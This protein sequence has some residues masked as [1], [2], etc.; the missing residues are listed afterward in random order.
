[1]PE[2]FGQGGTMGA[3]QSIRD[4]G[5]LLEMLSGIARMAGQGSD[6]QTALAIGRIPFGGSLSIFRRSADPTGL[7]SYALTKAMAMNPNIF[8][9]TIPIGG[10]SYD[11]YGDKGNLRF[12]RFLTS[13]LQRGGR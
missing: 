9:K 10:F 5:K 11:I 7:A 4:G 3:S 6:V 1:M 12:A 2:V 13:M 8:R